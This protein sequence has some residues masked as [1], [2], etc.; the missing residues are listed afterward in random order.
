MEILVLIKQVPD[1]SVEIKLD[2][3][4]GAPK[5]DGVEA[6]VNAFDTYA[7]EMAKRYIEDNGGNITVATISSNDSTRHICNCQKVLFVIYF[8]SCFSFSSRTNLS[9]RIDKEYLSR[10]RAIS[11]IIGDE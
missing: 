4:T 6:V 9:T 1:D 11:F 5:L 7:L 8:S 3:A 2:P 10:R